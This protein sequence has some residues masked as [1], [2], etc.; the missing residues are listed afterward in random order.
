MA[1]KILHKA[2][3]FENPKIAV[4]G[5][6]FKG[7][8]DDCRESP[9]VDIIKEMLNL[10]ARNITVYDP[11]ALD[12]A[13]SIFGT[14]LSYASSVTECIKDADLLITLTEWND[15]R[16]LDLTEIAKLMKHRV[17]EDYRNLFRPETAIQAGFEYS[18]IGRSY[19]N[20]K[21]AIAS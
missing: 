19:N 18:S 1:R 8:T 7:G 3:R 17:I 20:S 15:F 4:L 6:A 9:A 2:S 14:S 16:K 13:K 10:G 11:K 21:E 5:I 12:N